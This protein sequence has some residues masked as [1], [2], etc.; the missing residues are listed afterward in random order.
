MELEGKGHSTVT[1]HRQQEA[2][3]RVLAFFR[4]KLRAS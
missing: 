3:D 2:V 1:A 4:E